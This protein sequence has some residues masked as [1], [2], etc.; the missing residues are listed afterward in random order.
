M[1]VVNDVQ[2]GMRWEIEEWA[3]EVRG[4]GEDGGGG[5]GAGQSQSP[6]KTYNNQLV[7]GK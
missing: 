4:E 2:G 5:E 1:M 3:S 7:K 6:N